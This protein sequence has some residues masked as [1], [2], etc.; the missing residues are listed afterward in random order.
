MPGR[1]PWFPVR[2]SDGRVPLVAHGVYLFV[3]PTMSFGD[4]AWFPG[5]SVATFG[6][7]VPAAGAM[8]LS[9]GISFIVNYLAGREF[10]HRSPVQV[11]FTPMPRAVI[12]HNGVLVGGIAMVFYDTPLW[13]DIPWSWA[14]R[15]ST[16]WPISQNTSRSRTADTANEP[17]GGA[18]EVRDR[19]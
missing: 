1:I 13:S 11:T 9:H 19:G 5:V 8:A 15:A 12:L 3:F 4:A 10:R 18:A 2:P 17:R 14:R 16:S 7:L 6:L